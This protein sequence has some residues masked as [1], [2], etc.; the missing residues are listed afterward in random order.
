M[1]TSVP[2]LTPAPMDL[3]GVW[4]CDADLGDPDACC[5]DLYAWVLEISASDFGRPSESGRQIS[6][7]RSACRRDLSALQVLNAVAL[8]ARGP[9]GSA[10]PG[11]GGAVSGIQSRRAAK[12]ARSAEI[13]VQP[14]VVLVGSTIAL[15]R[16]ATA[17]RIGMSFTVL[18]RQH[19]SRRLGVSEIRASRE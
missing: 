2:S 15:A 8:Q 7:S 12:I 6:A 5:H 19:A 1:R 18:Q 9:L 3:H 17:T 14:C 13:G 10:G 16:I 11:A 4:G